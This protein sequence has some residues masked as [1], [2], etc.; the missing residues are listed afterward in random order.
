MFFSCFSNSIFFDFFTFVKEFYFYI[1]LLQHND[2]LFINN[3][4]LINKFKNKYLHYQI[5]STF[6]KIKKKL[7]VLNRVFP[8]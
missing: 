5:L 1:S 6:V 7:L 3:F 4:M 8:K 2:S